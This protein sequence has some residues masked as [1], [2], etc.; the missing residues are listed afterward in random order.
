MAAEAVVPLSK[1][2]FI[3]E[4]T[5]VHLT[6]GDYLIILAK[7]QLR[8]V[9]TNPDENPVYGDNF[10]LFKRTQG[11]DVEIIALDEEGLESSTEIKSFLEA[12]QTSHPLLEYVLLVGDVNGD[13]TIPTFFINSI[14]EDEE[15]VTDYPYS[16]FDEDPGSDNY[17]V[18][19]PQ[20][21]I[22]RW[23]I[24]NIGDLI[25]VKIRSME[26]VQLE[27]VQASEELNYFNNALLVAGNYKT[28]DGMEVPPEQWPVTPVWTSQWLNEQLSDYGYSS[29]DTAYFH[30]NYQV[31]ENPLIN[32]SWSNGVG[33]INYR[34]WGNS[35][36][37]HRPSFYI[38]DIN[39]LNHG[40]KLPVVMSFVCN[41]GDFGADLYPQTGPSKCFGEEL[42]TKGTPSNPKG[43]V[44]VIAPSDL[45][46][47]TKYN[48]VICGVMWDNLLEK[49]IAELGPAL[50][51]GKQALLEEFPQLSD[52][53]NVVEFYHHI[54]GILGDPSL[55]V[56]LTE[57]H[58]LSADIEATTLELHQSFL[59]T[60]IVSEEGVPLQNV[61]GVLLLNDISIGKGVSGPDG[62]LN[63]DFSEIA[64][65]SQLSLYLNLEQFLQ[66]KITLTFVEDDGTPYDPPLQGHFDVIPVLAS[67]EEFVEANQV[68]DLSLKITN[69]TEEEFNDITIELS[70]LDEG[71]INPSFTTVEEY[72]GAFTTVQTATVV[73]GQVADIPKGSKI[74]F[75]VE[76]VLDSEAIATDTVSILIGPI[77]SSDPL[78][79][80]E[81]GYWA[82][83]NSDTG[84][85]EA[86]TYNW[87]ELNP[88]LGGAG[89]NLGLTDDSHTDISIGFP[90]RYYGSW[91]DSITVCSNGWIS[92]EPCPIDYFWNF[93]IPMSMGPSGMLAPFMDDLDDNDGMEPFY[94]YTWH[95]PSN[96]RLIIQ[97]DNLANG[98]DDENCPDCVQE[99]FQLILLDPTL[100]PTTTGDGEILFQ[101]QQI[102]D[103]D[104][105]G[106]YSTVGIESPDQNVG[107]QYLFNGYLSPGAVL[108]TEGVA[109]KFTTDAP[110]NAIMK[111]GEPIRLAQGFILSPAYPN[112]FNAVTTLNFQLPVRSN[113]NIT[114]Y[115]ILGRNVFTLLKEVMETGIHQLHWNGR[116]NLGDVVSSGIY[117]VKLETESFSQT[118]KVLLLK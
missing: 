81:F 105:N 91:Y 100:N 69:L 12:Y 97:W 70:P 14:N 80:D 17:D 107:I 116:N 62:Q 60:F 8:D 29:I 33:I 53:G 47:D 51:S 84:Y 109:I 49:R 44:A 3:P 113:V 6:R 106:N 30:I 55:P 104:A 22:G 99:T 1:K 26:Y 88:E 83:D 57:P 35:H 13:Y 66:K 111:S 75:Q 52:P 108:P 67:E 92:F 40:W 32:E 117:F 43:A 86:P 74:R 48:N 64:E 39:N 45:D 85:E 89:Q 101:Y 18:L 9:L 16:F 23:S 46:T 5:A 50:F 11:Y 15:D 19:Y 71:V 59:Q 41:T 34:G 78:P 38:E 82:Y 93:S 114:V 65:G 103:I 112:P 76:F 58:Q 90:F 87:I 115:D 61:V 94:V 20:F 4:G 25:N 102:N 79:P 110:P 2:H 27:N 21:F 72:L 28:N 42:I 63:I 98:E 77:E 118:R 56:W 36:G 96:S 24:R 95:D 68:F 10:V 73:A 54:Y 31:I 37:W 7:S